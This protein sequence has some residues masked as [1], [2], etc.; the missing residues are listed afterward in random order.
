[1]MDETGLSRK[2]MP[3]RTKLVKEEAQALGFKAQ[4]DRATLLMCSIKY[5]TVLSTS[6]NLFYKAS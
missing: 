5:T 4:R 2:T 3:S 1:M 6:L